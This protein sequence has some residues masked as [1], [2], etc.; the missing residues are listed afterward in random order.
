MIGSAEIPSTSRREV[1]VMAKYELSMALSVEADSRIEAELKAIGFERVREYFGEGSGPLALD[2]PGL[3]WLHAGLSPRYRIPRR[4][5][6][7]R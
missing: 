4:G 5:H 1:Q 3:Q 2:I 7:Q 6:A